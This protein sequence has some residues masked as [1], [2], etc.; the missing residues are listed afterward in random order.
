MNYNEFLTRVIDEGIEAAK[1]DY[2]NKSDKDYLEGSIAGFEACRNKN[3]EELIEVW[4]EANDKYE[5]AF[6][7]QKNNYWWYRC[8]QLEVEWV[9]NVI[10]AML[11]N[12][13]QDSLL[14]W[15]P[16]ACAMM[17]AASIIGVSERN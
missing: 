12:E 17:K 8:F 13:G 16:T 3:P 7:K 6:Q 1:T 14:S 4:N 2:T 9:I 5:N 15:L 10:S 11:V